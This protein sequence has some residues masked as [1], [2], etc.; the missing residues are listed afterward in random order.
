MK[1]IDKYKGGLLIIDYGY[2]EEKFQNTLKAIYNKKHSNLLENIGK[3]DITYNINYYLFDR[4]VKNNKNLNNKYTTQK[5]FLTNLGIFQRAEIL[6]KNKKFSE[7]ADIFY[8]IKRL[9]DDEQ[10]GDLFK[11]MLI[12]NSSIKSQL[13]FEN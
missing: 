10:M 2:Y 5:K 4:I 1:F 8:R 11:V 9:T 3:S 13:G 12:K 7:K 6:S